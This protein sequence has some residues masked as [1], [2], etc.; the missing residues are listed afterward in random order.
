MAEL[1][2]LIRDQNIWAFIFSPPGCWLML[3]VSE[4]DPFQHGSYVPIKPLMTVALMAGRTHFKT[5]TFKM[6]SH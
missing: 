5:D 6:P 4:V 1:P 2:M 3:M